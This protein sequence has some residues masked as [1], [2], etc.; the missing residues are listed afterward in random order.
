MLTHI[1]HL[2][3]DLVHLGTLMRLYKN[4][5][6]EAFPLKEDW[7]TLLPSSY[8]TPTISIYSRKRTYCCLS[9]FWRETT[10]FIIF[11]L[12]TLYLPEIDLFPN[13][14]L[15]ILNLGQKYFHF[16]VVLSLIFPLF[17]EGKEKIEKTITLSYKT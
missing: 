12:C 1:Y 6:C 14:T 3:K 8:S 4:F 13:G 16:F 15:K 5:I 2:L 10:I 7:S 11:D 17:L 9:F